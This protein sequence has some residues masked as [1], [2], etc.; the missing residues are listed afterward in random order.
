[1]NKYENF[2][3]YK[4]YQ[5]S[6]PDMLYIGSSTNFSQRKSNHKKYCH[7]KTSKKYKYPLY[8][9]IRGCG[10]FGNFNIEIVE[11]YP[12]KTKEEGLRREKELIEF[13]D[14]KLNT[15]KPIK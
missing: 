6:V 14:A 15:I 8:Q 4:I 13:Y 3:I 2:I 1:M 11:K 12:C 7:C 9:Y 5:P 10:G